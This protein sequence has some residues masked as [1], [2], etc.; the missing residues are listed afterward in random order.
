VPGQWSLVDGPTGKLQTYA[1]A[2]SPGAPRRP[3]LVLCHELPRARNAGAEVGHTFP[4]LA[5]RLA[6]ESG[7]RVATARLR[8]A[9]SSKGDFSPAGWVADLSFVLDQ[10][11]VADER[12]CLVGF[13]FGGALA[14]RV[15]REDQRVSGV[16]VLGMPEDLSVW[17]DDP[18]ELVRV[19]RRSA[20]IH[21]RT[22]PKNPDTWSEELADLA[23]VTSLPGLVGRP[24][25][26]VHGTEDALVGAE[27]A[28]E[29]EQRGVSGQVDLRLI[30][31]GGHWLRADPRAIATLI[32][33]LERQR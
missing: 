22:F 14:L 24:L 12:A 1:T 26:V 32:G 25:L 5:D 4:D 8:G 9:G 33:W 6:Q 15:A 19:A 17:I 29:F 10:G 13:G 28:R 23:P 21:G 20:V 27:T 18:A 2:E 7:W 11:V 16:A 3:L 31:G 30:P